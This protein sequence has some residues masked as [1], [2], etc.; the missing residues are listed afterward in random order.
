MKKKSSYAIIGAAVLA[1]SIPAFASTNTGYYDGY[2]Y[3]VTANK[4]GNYAYGKFDYETTKS[5]SPGV[6]IWGV[7][8]GKSGARVSYGTEWGTYSVTYKSPLGNIVSV[9]AEGFVN[10][11]SVGIASE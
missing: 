9:N 2:K 6:A 5:F 7:R 1:I 11:T 8:Y 3:T 10:S 4:S